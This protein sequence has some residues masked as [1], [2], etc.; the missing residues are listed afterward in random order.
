MAKNKKLLVNVFSRIF[1]FINL[2][3][4]NVR[5]FV[6]SRLDLVGNSDIVIGKEEKKMYEKLPQEL[7]WMESR[8]EKLDVL[9]Q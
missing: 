9:M 6:L 2:F 5:I 7:T 3:L 4:K 8:I 1:H